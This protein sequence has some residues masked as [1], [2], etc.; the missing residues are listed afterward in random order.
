M[1]AR[2]LLTHLGSSEVTASGSTSFPSSVRR[3]FLHLPCICSMYF[4]CVH[5]LECEFLPESILISFIGNP[6][7]SS[8]LPEISPQSNCMFYK[9]A[10]MCWSQPKS[11]NYWLW[12]FFPKTRKKKLGITKKHLMLCTDEQTTFSLFIW[13]FWHGIEIVASRFFMFDENPTRIQELSPLHLRKL[14]AI[15][16]YKV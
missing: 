13:A 9:H 10:G 8:L 12:K 3:L 5:H 16:L 15:N 2:Q 4:S 1:W 7:I 14:T 11:I 6:Q